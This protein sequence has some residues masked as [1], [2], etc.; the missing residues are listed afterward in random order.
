MLPFKSAWDAGDQSAVGRLLGYPACCSAFFQRVWVNDRSVDTTWAIASGMCADTTPRTID[1]AGHP[2]ANILLRWLGV[3]AVPHLPCSFASWDTVRLADGLLHVASESGFAAEAEWIIEMLSW[4]VEWSALHGIAEIKAPVVKIATRTDATAD[5]YVVRR[6][7][8]SYPTEGARGTA[9]PFQR[10]ALQEPLP[11]SVPASV[12]P[13]ARDA[14]AHPIVVR[15][16][17]EHWYATDNGFASEAAMTA[18]H[19]PILELAGEHLAGRSGAVLDLGCGNGAL[20]EALCA[21]N[22]TLVPLGVDADPQKIA[23]AR[24]LQPGFM[25]G[26]FA[27]DIFE[28]EAPWMHRR[29]DLIIVMLGRLLE[30]D[31]GRA[32]RLREWLRATG[33]RCSSTPTTTGSRSTELSKACAFG[34]AC[35]SHPAAVAAP[36]LPRY[37]AAAHRVVHDVTFDD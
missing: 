3:R 37:Y 2:Q 8:Q 34:Q 28:P 29:A 4:P 35:R 21:G 20:L 7:G 26:F 6:K 36:H 32:E 31:A 18:A 12:P 17:R 10:T 1:V 22:S 30:V 25:D 13:S 5:N 27:G 16:R 33:A 14:L 23:H 9:F 15:R 24:V 11:A 19:R